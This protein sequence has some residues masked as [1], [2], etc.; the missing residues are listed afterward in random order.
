MIL[1]TVISGYMYSIT[2]SYCWP[3]MV[4]QGLDICDTLG[5]SKLSIGL[6][7]VSCGHSKLC[8]DCSSMTFNSG[9]VAISSLQSLSCS[10]SLLNC[11][12][13]S[14]FRS[15][16]CIICNSIV[17]SCGWSRTDQGFNRIEGWLGRLFVSKT[18][19]CACLS[20]IDCLIDIRG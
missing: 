11:N 8:G 15:V 14:R 6:I 3:F 13:T 1:R 10:W 2:M 12:S 4:F 5:S 9:L 20:F 7:I 17:G 16:G 18:V 19:V